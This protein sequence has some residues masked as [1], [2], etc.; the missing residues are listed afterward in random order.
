M[1]ELVLREVNQVSFY[2]F[3]VDEVLVHPWEKGQH[4]TVEISLQIFLLE[5]LYFRKANFARNENKIAFKGVFKRRIENREP[6]FL[7]KNYV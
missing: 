5:R 4:V 1:S 7:Q 6:I 3:L 2:N